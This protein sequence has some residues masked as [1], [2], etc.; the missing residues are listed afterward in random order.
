M[1]SVIGEAVVGK[2]FEIAVEMAVQ[3]LTEE[4]NLVR[5]FRQDFRWLNKKLRYVRG[6]LRDADQQS[7]HN[8]DVKEWLESIR[9]FV[10]HAEDIFEEYAV[11][12]MYGDNAQSCELSRN[13][14]IFRWR[15]AWKIRGMKNRMRSLIEDGTS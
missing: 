9:D 15:M 1:A 13:Q 14:L 11:E 4:A 2:V 3:K 12:S 6:F 8:K 5:N 10:L 7:R